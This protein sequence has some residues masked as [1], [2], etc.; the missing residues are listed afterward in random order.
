MTKTVDTSVTTRASSLLAALEPCIQS[1]VGTL[2]TNYML[3][4]GFR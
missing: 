1:T 2:T 4:I 3:A